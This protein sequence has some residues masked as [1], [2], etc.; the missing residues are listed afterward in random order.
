VDAP[1]YIGDERGDAPL[2]EPGLRQAWPACTDV[3]EEGQC[4]AT[5]VTRRDV[6]RAD[7]HDQQ[8]TCVEAEQASKLHLWRQRCEGRWRRR[9]E[10]EWRI[11]K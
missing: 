8:A 5:T 6:G 7:G 2:S 1:A 9:R 3:E 11:H 4:V 10:E